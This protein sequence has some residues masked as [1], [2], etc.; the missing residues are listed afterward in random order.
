MTYH[1]VVQVS[2]VPPSGRSG[3]WRSYLRSARGRPIRLGAAFGALLLLL[4]LGVA[5]VY[6]AGSSTATAQAA[7]A[8]GL[9]GWAT[10]GGGTTGG[11]DASPTTVSSSAELEDAISGD[12]EAVVRVS[13]K[14]SCSGTLSVGS[15]KSIV[16]ESG[17]TLKGCG[18]NVSKASNVIIQHITFLDADDDAI[19]VQ[20]STRVWIDHN[21]FSGCNDGCTDIKRASDY[22]TVSWNHYADVHKTI[23]LGHSDDNGDEDIGHLRV[24]YHH[25]WF[26]GSDTRHPRVR[27]GNPVHV[28][29]NYYHD[30]DYGVASTMDACVLVEANSF[31]GVKDS[32]HVGYAS[33]DP[34]DL[35]M[36]DNELAESGEPETAG[37]SCKSLPYSYSAEPASSVKADVTSGAGA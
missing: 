16:G 26:D 22:V 34:G 13:G 36:R 23:L 24:T 32:T 21:S 20:Y 28:F 25:N 11:G 37:S 35:V 3:R 9:V 30:N 29:N 33:S 8:D 18:L 7:S 4:Y 19:N 6:L 15:N 12:S 5:V 2:G 14:I 10:Q 31:E 1:S 27:F 17:A